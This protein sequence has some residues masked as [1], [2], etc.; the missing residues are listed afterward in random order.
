M[1]KPPYKVPT[2]KEISEL[3]WNG[4]NVVSTFS[5][6][7]GSCLGYRMA[8]Y[9]VVYANEFVEEARRTY[10]QNHPHSFLDGYDIRKVTPERIFENTGLKAGE[11]DIFDGSPPCSAFST[12]GKREKGWGREKKY[13]DGKVQQIENLFFEYSRL[14]N[15]LQPKVFIAE[16]V[17]GLV[18]GKA[19]GYFIDIIKELRSCGYN[20]KAKLLNSQW[21]GVPQSR[22][23]L[24]FMGVRKDLG[25]DPVFPKPL[26]YY[27]MLRDIFEDLPP[28]NAENA[29]MLEKTIKR[30]KVYS[31]IKKMPR[32]P[33]KRIK[34][35]DYTGGSYFNLVRE[36]MT[37]PASTICQTAGQPGI[38]STIHPLYDRKFTIE[39]LRR[40]QSLPDDFILTGTYQQQYERIGRM[41]PPVMM[42]HI[43]KT[44]EREILCKIR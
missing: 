23:R 42:M 22:E 1:N 20:V 9:K 3:E 24:I 18:K 40:M 4:F 43:A 19:K 29:L 34:G 12:A 2:M 27:Y 33:S 37:R 31:I 39:E 38:S 11:I 14:L 26:P 13:S 6:G 30:Y 8:N 10:K 36:C 41:V 21:L 7:G 17:S 35:Q 28:T 16:N 32:N 5:G 44:V 15:G 25:M